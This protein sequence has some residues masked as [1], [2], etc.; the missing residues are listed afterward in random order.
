MVLIDESGRLMRGITMGFNSWVTHVLCAMQQERACHSG[1]LMALGGRQSVFLTKHQVAAI[2][3]GYGV[4]RERLELLLADTEVDME[5]LR[6]RGGVTDRTYVKALVNAST[7]SF[8]ATAYEHADSVLDLNR[9]FDSQGAQG[10][11]SSADIV[12]DGGCLDN[13]FDPQM[14]LRNLCSLLKPGGRIVNWACAS[15]WPGAYAMVSPE[16]LLSFYAI[17]GFSEIRVY[18]AIPLSGPGSW[19]NLDVALF[20]Y[21]PQFTRDAAWD[22]WAAMQKDPGHPC[23]VLAVAQTSHSLAPLEWKTPMQS[24]YLTG[25]LHDWR[26]D[27]VEATGLPPRFTTAGMGSDVPGPPYGSDHFEFSG[28]LPG[29]PA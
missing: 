28:V 24:H 4:P 1:A 16:W 6:T 21:S 27:Y 18:V 12:Y 9:A 7:F 2:A 25:G 11:L 8:D 23:F 26:D 14:A 15:N 5:T 22:P 13:V 3:K 29:V 10:V 19:P 20:R 17:N